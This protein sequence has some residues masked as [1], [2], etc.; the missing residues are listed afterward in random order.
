MNEGQ[1]IP[2]MVDGGSWSSAFGLSW[3]AAMLRDQASPVPRIIRED[4]QYMRIVSGTMGVAAARSKIVSQFLATR[5]EWLFMVDT[6]MGFEDDTIERLI[7]ASEA[8]SCPVVGALCFAQKAD[9]R[10]PETSLHAQRF[11][12][13]PTLYRYVDL[14]TERGFL[15]ITDYAPNQFQFV[16]ATGAAAILM[17]RDAL[18]A[19]GPEPFR[20]MVVRGANPDGTDREFSEDLSFC[21]RLA[22]AGVAMGV[23]TSVKTTHHKGGIFLDET[24]YQVQRMVRTRNPLG[25]TQAQMADPDKSLADTLDMARKAG[26]VA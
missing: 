3:T 9:P 14:G 4:G 12:I 25:V 22:N 23:D 6:D 21:A 7:Q 26:I 18:R 16:D 17:H 8:N 11:T 15:S 1:V 13:V 10:V 19:V 5:A 20:P 2:S 24:T